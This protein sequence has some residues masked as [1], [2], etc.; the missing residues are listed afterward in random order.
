MVTIS[1]LGGGDVH[2]GKVIREGEG[3]KSGHWSREL[4]VAEC[5]AREKTVVTHN[6]LQAGRKK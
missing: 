4:R 3:R 5:K 1:R 2:P 6:K